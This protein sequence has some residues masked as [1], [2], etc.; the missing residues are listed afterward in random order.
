MAFLGINQGTQSFVFFEAEGTGFLQGVAVQRGTVT[1][2]NP[3]GTTVQFNNGTIDLLKAGTISSLPNLPGGTLGLVTRVG[4][5]GTL[6]AG[7]VTVV[8]SITNLAGGTVTR[9]V[10]G[11][12]R[13][14]AGTITSVTDVANLSKGTITSVESGSIAVTSIPQVS[15]GTLPNLPGGSVVVTTGTVTPAPSTTPTVASVQGTNVTSALLAANTARKG[16][17]IYND[18]TAVLYTRLGTA[19]VSSGTYTLQ[20]H[21]Q[22]YYEV[23]Y[24]YTGAIQGIWAANNGSAFVTEIT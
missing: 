17:T 2:S 16:A 4:N 1:L 24:A 12:I 7:T 14:P 18:S 3:T 15:V 9:L 6:E 19:A 10:D 22:A 20:I 21:P 5:L 23:P 8:S 13:I 11:T